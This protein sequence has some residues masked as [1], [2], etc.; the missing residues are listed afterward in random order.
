M[1]PPV[2]TCDVLLVR[3][4]E[5]SVDPAE[6]TRVIAEMR[7]RGVEVVFMHLNKSITYPST[8]VM[9]CSGKSA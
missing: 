6:E 2:T 8:D 9:Q 4:V 3:L 7:T 5:G 1:A